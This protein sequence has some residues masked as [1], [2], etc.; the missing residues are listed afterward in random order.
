MTGVG[1]DTASTS[2]PGS[3]G[4]SSTGAGALKKTPVEVSRLMTGASAATWEL[5]SRR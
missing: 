3:S 4:R 2:L 1:Q 5:T